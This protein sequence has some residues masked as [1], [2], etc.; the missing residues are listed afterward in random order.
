MSLSP[1]Q[2]RTRE[3]LQKEHD[4]YWRQRRERQQKQQLREQN[5]QKYPTEEFKFFIRYHINSLRRKYD[6][7]FNT[8]NNSKK[9]SKND[10]WLEEVSSFRQNILEGHV[11]P[12]FL[13]NCEMYLSELIV[14][15]IKLYE[16]QF[17]SQYLDTMSGIEYENFCKSILEKNGW[18]CSLTVQ[19]GDQGGDIIAKRQNKTVVFQCKRYV[20]S[21]GNKAIQ[22]VYA[23]K[24]FY[25]A[26]ECAVVSNANYTKSA[27]ELAQSLSV[28]LFHHAD[29][30]NI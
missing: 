26:D 11:L 5:L 24:G 1:E 4:E 23:A 19:S 6:E 13:L 8:A 30:D 12:H 22:E 20:A 3:E 27:K 7:C 2:E 9:C 29:L 18:T 25:K 10:K 14:E 17:N 16:P 15:E 21:V 28:T